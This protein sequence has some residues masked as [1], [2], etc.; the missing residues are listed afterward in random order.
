MDTLRHAEYYGMLQTFDDLYAKSKSGEKF[1][2]LMELIL[3]QDNI[4]LAYRNIKSN[5]GSYT[6]GTD[7][8]NIGDIGK[9]PPSVVI[10][11]VRKIV[12][13]SQHGYRP[14]PVR[15]KDIPKP[16]GKTRPLGI[17]CIWDR[18]VK[19]GKIRRLLQRIT[20]HYSPKLPCSKPL[21]CTCC[22]RPRPK[23]KTSRW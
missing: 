11:K 8:Q 20:Y 7:H 21:C 14:K 10:E 3:S 17:P 2:N 15:R 4:M 16:N 23:N 9:L 12:T 18:L 5:T 19:W 22:T 1:P 6:A 13:G